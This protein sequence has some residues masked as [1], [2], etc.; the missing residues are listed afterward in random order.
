MHSL[1]LINSLTLTERART[2]W[3]MKNGHQRHI[4][5]SMQWAHHSSSD[6]T[7]SL[8][9]HLVYSKHKFQSIKTITFLIVSRMQTKLINILW[10]QHFTASHSSSTTLTLQLS[11]SKLPFNEL[12]HLGYAIPSNECGHSGQHQHTLTQ[13][14]TKDH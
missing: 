7:T 13:Q 5:S 9:R 10:T 6:A 4:T 12:C 3:E 2:Q 8:M 14:C 11:V 1:G